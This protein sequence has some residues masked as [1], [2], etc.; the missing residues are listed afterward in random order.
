MTDKKEEIKYDGSTEEMMRLGLIDEA[1]NVNNKMR[2]QFN[3]YMKVVWEKE[4]P[5]EM[6][7]YN[8][9]YPTDDDLREYFANQEKLKVERTTRRRAFWDRVFG[10]NKQN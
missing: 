7:P 2:N 10:R 5:G 9:K 4:H 3:Q 6:S 1:G 8:D